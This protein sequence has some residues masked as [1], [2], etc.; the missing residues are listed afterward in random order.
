MLHKSARSIWRHRDLRLMISAQAV[1]AFGDDLAVIVLMLRVYSHGLGPWSVT[2][3]LLC[4]AL[5]VALLAPLAGRL[6]DAVPFRALA[7]T[8]ACWQALFCVALAF[9][10]PL[11]SIYLLV[12]ALQTGQV[13]AGP[14]WGALLPALAEPDEL[15]RAVSVSQAT[16]RLAAVAAP[17]AAGIAVGR[18]GSG[19]PLLVDAATFAVLGIAGLAIRTRRHLE[20]GTLDESSP[21]AQPGF[22]LRADTL[23]WPLVVG[24]CALVLVGG[25]TNVVEVFLVRGSL[26]AGPIT[27]GLLAGLFAAA[28]VAGALAVGR[29]APDP[30]RAVR[31]VVAALV[32]A[33][34]LVAGGL[35]P[36]IWAFAIAWA[37]LGVANGSLNADVSTL[38]LNRAP[39]AF[40]GRVL[41]RVNSMVRSAEIAA[42]A[43]GGV[44][45][46]LLGPRT[47]FAAGGALM[48]LV[49]IALLARVRPHLTEATPRTGLVCD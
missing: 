17:A 24:I 36:A 41:A 28:L 15:G 2:G 20:P 27:F 42:L 39:A 43:I 10:T 4:S 12:L 40:R 3:L 21:N 19:P 46:S 44:A 1:S 18:I 37:V 34:A 7:V 38:L 16:T 30:A 6:V 31:A 48:A 25:I 33:L 11:W 23:L 32:I 45:G 26:H 5:P 22:T 9:A 29:N 13:V 14:T 8:S 47:T 35:A 49:A